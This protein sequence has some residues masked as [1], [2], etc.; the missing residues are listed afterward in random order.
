MEQPN[1]EGVFEVIDSFAIRKKKQFYLIGSL[2]TGRVEKNWFVSIPFNSSLSMTVRITGIEEVEMASE[3]EPHLLL[4]VDCDDEAIDFYMALNIRLE[5][6]PITI[7][8]ED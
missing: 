3:K 1:P 2:K 6:L 4:I 8:G 5:Y 7:K